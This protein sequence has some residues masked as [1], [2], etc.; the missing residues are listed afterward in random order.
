LPAEQNPASC[1]PPIT[2]TL[3]RADNLDIYDVA[4]TTNGVFLELFGAHVFSL[5][6]QQGLS[7]YFFTRDTNPLP[8]CLSRKAA[9]T[10]PANHS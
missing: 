4:W 7:R 8:G 3:A 1:T 9:K 5:E 6:V 10:P 2:W